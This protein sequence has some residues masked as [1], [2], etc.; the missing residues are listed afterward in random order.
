MWERLK[1]VDQVQDDLNRPA[2]SAARIVKFRT[3]GDELSSVIREA[4]NAKLG[5]VRHSP[6]PFRETM[7][8]REQ[9]RPR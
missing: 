2:C 3:I 6:V 9:L 1:P 7:S 4:C 8:H 5:H